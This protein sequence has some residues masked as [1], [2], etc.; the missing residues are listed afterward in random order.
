MK[1]FQKE[2]L[3][4]AIESKAIRFGSFVL[5][6]GRMSPYFFNS[7]MFLANGKLNTLAECYVNK[8]KNEN[9]KFDMLFGPAYKG[10]FLAT[11]ISTKLS[12]SRTVPVCFNR[13]EEKDHGEGGSYIGKKPFGKVLIVDDV[14]SSGLAIGESIEFLKNFDVE[15][16]GAIVGLNRLERG[17]KTSQ[18]ASDE[19]KNEGINIYALMT[20]DEIMLDEDLITQSQIKEIKAYRDQ[21]S[22]ENV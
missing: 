8:I 12:Q 10:I 13:K 20:I 5:K 19:L 6:S 22:G 15:I 1:K 4:L 21:Y 16:I 3:K 14:L 11:A 7:A 9:L 2:F 18:V 17:Q